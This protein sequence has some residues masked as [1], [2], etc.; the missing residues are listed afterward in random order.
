MDCLIR[1]LECDRSD[2]EIMGYALE[3]ISNVINAPRDDE[4]KHVFILFLSIST[5]SQVILQSNIFNLF[6]SAQDFMP[7]DN[8]GLQFTEIFIKKPENVSLLLELIEVPHVV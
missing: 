4:S 2:N 7:E 1:V 8:L 6:I 5:T 3:A